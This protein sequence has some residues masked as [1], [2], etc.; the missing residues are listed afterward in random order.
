MAGQPYYNAMN[1]QP[2]IMGNTV[3]AVA[4]YAQ[5]VYQPIQQP[6]QS[7]YMIQ[8]DG[9]MAARAWQMPANLMP[10]TVIP[11]WDV[12]GI[13]VYFKSV[14][15]YGRLNPTRKARIVFEDESAN[16]PEGSS[17]ASAPVSENYIT[18]ADF[19]TFRN[20]IKQLIS[21]NRQ[22]GS[23]T[24]YRQNGGQAQQKGGGDNA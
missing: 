3:P 19:D 17:G 16:L 10:G 4:G 12:D 11:I 14:D 8:A 6:S 21:G 13:H 23:Y 9:E 5:P 18:K 7:P 15:G 1:G 24:S 20:E 2:Y 22:N